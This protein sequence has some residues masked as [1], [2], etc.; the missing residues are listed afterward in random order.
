MAMIVREA[1]LSDAERLAELM[2]QLG[3]SIEPS[4]LADKISSFNNGYGDAVFVAELNNNIVG[5]ISC[6]ITNLLHQP[7]SSGRITSL[8]VDHE[9]RGNGIG[10]KLV[11]TAEDFFTRRQCEK[12][13][14]TSGLER[15]D[16]H[17]F[18]QSLGYQANNLRFI[19]A[20]VVE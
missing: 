4:V 15:S 3:Y 18:Y 17:R 11:A 9:V 5:F 10:K 8:L 13:E 14:V 19:K 16:A 1:K 2:P 12:F 7:G 6:H 20:V